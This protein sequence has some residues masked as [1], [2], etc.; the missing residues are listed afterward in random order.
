VDFGLAGRCSPSSKSCSLVDVVGTTKYMAPEVIRGGPYDTRCDVWGVGVVCFLLLSHGWLPFDGNSDKAIEAQVCRSERYLEFL[1]HRGWAHVSDGAVKFVKACLTPNFRKR[2]TAETL[3][4]TNAWLLTPTKAPTQPT[5]EVLTSSASPPLPADAASVT[6]ATATATSSFKVDKD[7]DADIC[8]ATGKEVKNDDYAAA[9]GAVDSADLT[10]AAANLTTATTN[11]D[12]AFDD[13]DDANYANAGESSVLRRDFSASI[14]GRQ[15]MRFTDNGTKGNTTLDVY[16]LEV[17]SSASASAS[18]SASAQHQT[19]TLS[20]ARADQSSIDRNQ[21]RRVLWVRYNSFRELHARLTAVTTAMALE[22]NNA[23]RHTAMATPSSCLS[24]FSSFSPSPL[25]SSSSSSSSPQ[26]P[27][28]SQ[29][30]DDEDE[31]QSEDSGGGGFVNLFAF[32]PKLFVHTAATLQA[33]QH[34]LASWVSAVVKHVN[35]ATVND[36]PND[37]PN[38]NSNSNSRKKKK[39]EEGG[40]P[41]SWRGAVLGV[42][43]RWLAEVEGLQPF[44]TPLFTSTAHE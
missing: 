26:Q 17:S 35:A 6:T 5:A 28:P 40:A 39:E 43:Q 13:D 27:P 11:Q 29:Q 18:V 12:H 2:P 41:H 25:P 16:A 23:P 20:A 30:K 34:A 14:V 21:R 31:A 7:D 8:G 4:A 44:L 10:V 38:S 33:R 36:E 22:N 9:A 15:E 1:G 24:P 3:C 32:P 42:W 19:P 37:K